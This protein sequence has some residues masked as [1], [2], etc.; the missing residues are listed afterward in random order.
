MLEFFIKLTYS[1]SAIIGYSF[2]IVIHIL[3]IG[4]NL[5][6]L[7]SFSTSL[8]F[9]QCR[10]GHTCLRFHK[11]IIY[12][13]TRTESF[14]PLPMATATTSFLKVSLTIFLAS[15]TISTASASVLNP[16]TERKNLKAFLISIQIKREASKRGRFRGKSLPFVKHC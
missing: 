14:M 8:C 1:I 13:A 10:R 12:S 16:A 15:C 3:I 9:S 4:K 2:S 5:N 6:C 7:S 11:P